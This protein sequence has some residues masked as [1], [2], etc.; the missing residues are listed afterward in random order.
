MIKFEG[1]LTEFTQEK[2]C[3][4]I[5]RPNGTERTLCP[6]CKDH[7]QE[8]CDEYNDCKTIIYKDELDA[9]GKLQQVGQCCCY[10]KEHK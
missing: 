9:Q 7:D 4:T 5:T 3:T 2:D 10:S 6:K 8:D 1:I